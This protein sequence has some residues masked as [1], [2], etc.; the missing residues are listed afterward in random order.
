MKTIYYGKLVRDNIPSIIEKE[1]KKAKVRLLNDNERGQALKN[2]LLEEAQELFEAITKDEV[3]KESADVLEVIFAII[4]AN[5]LKLDDVEAIRK[6]RADSRG[7]FKN[8]VF[9]EE[10]YEKDEVCPSERHS[11]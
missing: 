7:S 11:G 2:K 10:V 9:L 8:W 5:G 4:E 3:A 1:G 6:K